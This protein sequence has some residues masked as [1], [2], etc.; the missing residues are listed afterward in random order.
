MSNF[1]LIC[2][3]YFIIFKISFA[4]RESWAGTLID[5]LGPYTAD[6]EAEDE[7]E[8]S[9]PKSIPCGSCRTAIKQDAI[10]YCIHCEKAFCETDEQVSIKTSTCANRL[11]ATAYP[12]LL[13]FCIHGGGGGANLSHP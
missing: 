9:A 13:F 4:F 12:T 2:L 7:E 10:V 3:T 1:L 5:S 11:V 6:A 8:I